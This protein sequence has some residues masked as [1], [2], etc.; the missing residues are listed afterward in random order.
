MGIRISKDIGYY[1]PKKILKSIIKP[2]YQDILEDLDMDEEKAE[3]FK[4]DVQYLMENHATLSSSID[5]EVESHMLYYAIHNKEYD[6]TPTDLVRTVYNCDDEH[7][8]MFRTPELVKKSHFDDDIDYYESVD[9]FKFKALLLNRPIYPV[10]GFIFKGT[11]NQEILDYFKRFD[12]KKELIQGMV[13]EGNRL[14]TLLYILNQK[15]FEGGKFYKE[16]RK[17]NAFHPNVEPL[18]WIIAKASGILLDNVDEFKFRTTVE[19]AIVTTWG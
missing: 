19:P 12:D 16:V 7:G 11:S 1:L 18:A 3:K 14:N 15:S 5:A 8:L 6:W 2:K 13:V 10:S 4:S 9:H 17:T